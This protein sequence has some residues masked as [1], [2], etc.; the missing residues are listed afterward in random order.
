MPALVRAA[1]ANS[2]INFAAVAV[3]GKGWTDVNLAAT[4]E[5]NLVAFCDV[6]KGKGRKGGGWGAAS[7]KWPD[8][9]TYQ[10]WRKLFDDSKDVDA[11]TCST[12]DHMHASITLTAMRLGKH[13][14]CQKPLTHTI[15]EAR[16]LLTEARKCKV[17][18]QMGIQN[19]SLIGH[20]MTAALIQQG[21]IGK[22]SEV[23][24]WSF[25]R[26]AG[27]PEG[28]PDKSDPVPDNLDWDL[29]LGVAP[30]RPY[31]ERLYTPM[32]WRGWID[33][34]TGT[35]GDMGI[36]IYEPMVTT[37][38]VGAPKSITSEGPAANPET[39]TPSNRIR[40]EFPGTQYTAGDTLKFTWY[41]GEYAP[42]GHEICSHIPKD[43]KMPTQGTV[44]IGEKGCVVHAHMGGPVIYP[45]ELKNGLDVPKLAP[46][47][48][49][50]NWRDAILHGGEACANFDFAAPLT[51]TV[52]LGSIAVRYPNQRLEWDGAAMKFTNVADA[53]QHLRN[54]YRN[55]WSIE[56]LG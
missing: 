28:R 38:G 39:W 21:V 26:W 4:K 42:P 13:V 46:R 24:S 17:K 54:E 53:N 18:T 32:N 25:K 6:L 40:Y 44:F 8:A 20:R 31:V 14:Y 19:Q 9:R 45:V 35:L 5:H 22:V 27:P 37:L 56:G 30:Q 23:H 15:H 33:F 3:G 55:G 2:K 41:D 16:V 50:G 1:S 7:E 34:G 48:H 51:E 10:D 52:L 11:I 49:Y 47:D 12:P 36:H 29:W 43:M